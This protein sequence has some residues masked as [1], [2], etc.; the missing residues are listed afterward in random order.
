MSECTHDP[1][2]CWT[3]FSCLFSGQCRADMAQRADLLSKQVRNLLLL[4]KLES[5]SRKPNTV[6]WQTELRR[7]TTP[8]LPTRHATEA[9]LATSLWKV[10]LA[11]R[12]RFL[13][14]CTWHQS[15]KG[16]ESSLC[17]PNKE[18]VHR[19]KKKQTAG[20]NSLQETLPAE[21]DFFFLAIVKT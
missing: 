7:Q 16:A 1:W 5:L 3:L 13:V 9:A 17:S 19:L 21:P 12:P 18:T 6:C 20:K 10:S 14:Q 4:W 2:T 15:R 11:V 8:Q